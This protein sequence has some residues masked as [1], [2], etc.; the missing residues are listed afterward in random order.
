MKNNS[1]KRKRS[2]ET[3]KQHKLQSGKET[4]KAKGV[5][6]MEQLTGEQSLL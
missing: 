4:G 2:T 6:E 3:Q 1:R 5:R